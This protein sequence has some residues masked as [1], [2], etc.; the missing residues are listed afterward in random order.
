MKQCCSIPLIRCD[1][2][3]ALKAVNSHNKEM[4]ETTG[5]TVPD[6]KPPDEGQ[7]DK[8]TEVRSSS[9][10]RKVINYKQFLEEYADAPPTPP[11]KKRE[12]D[13]KCKPSKQRIAADKFRSKFITKPTHLPRLVR[14]KITKRDSGAPSKPTTDPQPSPSDTSAPKSNTVLT[15]ANSTETQ[16]VIEALLMLGDM[17]NVENNPLPDD[18]NA[19]LVPIMG[20]APN[21][22]QDALQASDAT[23]PPHP[24]KKL[25]HW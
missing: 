6:N 4:Q 20:T 9:H 23:E 17:P 25:S 5:N 16:E 18:D 15:S 10:P 7:T 2:D 12:V 8:S 14:N 19:L 3:S 22:A 21:E 24:T 1:F 13:L 11:R